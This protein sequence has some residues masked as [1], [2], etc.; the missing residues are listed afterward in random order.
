[1][2]TLRQ[3]D[4]ESKF[5]SELHLEAIDRAVP[6]G[7]I[8]AALQATGVQEVRER[9]LNLRMVVLLSIAM[10][11]YAR[12]SIGQVMH[13]IAR[14]LR[15][16]WPDPDYALPH[17]SALAYRRY[18]L[19]ARPLVNLFH[20][21]CRPMATPETPGAFLFGLR[22]MAIDGTVENAA[23]TAANVAAFG[24]HGGGEVTAPL[25]KS[26]G[27]T[28]SNVAPMPSSMLA[29]GLAAPANESGAF[30]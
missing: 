25:L 11:I 1:M 30:G 15:Y 7:E 8:K 17:D 28:W 29:S 16:V 3:I 2:F 18:Q 27:C 19:G 6:M 24:R 21:V 22:L 26:K 23:D 13:R 9:K 10:S 12:L 14:G 4:P 20:R 5:S